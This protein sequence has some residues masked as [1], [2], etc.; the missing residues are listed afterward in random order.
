MTRLAPSST[1][2][3]A[4]PAG[5]LGVGKLPG[6]IGAEAALD[7]LPARLQLW[8]VTVTFALLTGVPGRAG[9][10]LRTA[11]C[12]AGSS[13]VAVAVLA[14]RHEDARGSSGGRI[15]IGVGIW[16][17]VGAA[18]GVDGVGRGEREQRRRVQGRDRP[19]IA[20]NA[21]ASVIPV[22]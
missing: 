19:P 3:S 14:R 21:S 17:V 8:S 20:P 5:N 2:T 12:S 16:V 11:R 13:T 9:A 10:P 18:S 1:Q 22:R 15:G 6:G 7:R 4:R